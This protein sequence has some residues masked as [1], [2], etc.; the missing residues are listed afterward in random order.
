MDNSPTPIGRILIAEDTAEIAYLI[1]QVLEHAGYEVETTLDGPS[2]LE[3]ARE[4]RPDLLI[5]D[6]ML[7]GMHGIDVLRELQDDPATKEIGVLMCTAKDFSTD[8]RRSLE[9]GAI[10]VLVKPFH[11]SELLEAVNGFF[12]ALGREIPN[13]PIP[14]LVEDPPEAAFVMLP[15]TLRPRIQLWGSR[16]SIPTPGPN[17]VRHGGQTS[18]LSVI[19]NDECYIFDAGSGIRELGLELVNSQIRR[20]HLFITHTHWDHIQGFPFFLP[21]YRPDFEITIYGASGFG[22]DL[23][24]LFRGQLDKDYFP[25]Q[26]EDL[27]AEIKFQLLNDPPLELGAVEVSWTFAEHPGSTLS[28][29]LEIEGRSLVWAPDNEIFMGYLGDPLALHRYHPAVQPF[30]NY[31]RF[32]D[33]TDLVIHEAQFT[34][35]EY[36]ERVGYGHSSLSNAA[37]LI[38]LAD[39]KRWLITHHDPTHDDRFLERKLDLTRQMLERI[40]HPCRV[41][42][43]YDGW[44]ETF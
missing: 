35:Q 20:L 22:K 44:M 5:L 38:R 25:V 4:T 6:I 33:G 29:K 21:A 1:H 18:C 11:P 10:G 43:A 23:P 13:R 36:P 37:A 7:P 17:Y 26:L 39:V 15:D 12:A 9:L 2:S 31:I 14:E 8:H 32:L 3:R 19:H 40:N 28:Y 41:D 16:G 42:H 34:N 27:S 24:S 30:D